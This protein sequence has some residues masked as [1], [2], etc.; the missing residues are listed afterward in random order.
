M[1]PCRAEQSFL[2]I[3]VVTLFMQEIPLTFEVFQRMYLSRTELDMLYEIM[4][5]G[6]KYG[7][8]C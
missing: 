1:E 4:S 7:P 5:Q 8:Q 2:T 6:G 3:C